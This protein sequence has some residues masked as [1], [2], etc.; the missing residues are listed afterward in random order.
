MLRMGISR[1]EGSC[2]DLE[3]RRSGERVDERV[4]SFRRRDSFA[5]LERRAFEE[6][7]WG[8]GRAGVV[9]PIGPGM[10]DESLGCSLGGVRSRGPRRGHVHGVGGRAGLVIRIMP[11]DA[12]AC[13]GRHGCH[14]GRRGHRHRPHRA[15]VRV[16]GTRR[17]VG[18]LSGMAGRPGGGRCPFVP[19]PCATPGLVVNGRRVVFRDRP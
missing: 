12:L 19:R 8:A 16:P 5:S 6:G 2:R 7:E 13:S 9:W 11:P 4:R 14:A 15:A 18:R 17:V 10:K 1:D 3:A